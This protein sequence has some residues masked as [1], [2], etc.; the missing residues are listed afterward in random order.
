MPDV[1]NSNQIVNRGVTF[2]SKKERYCLSPAISCNLQHHT[3]V[4]VG[5]RIKRKETTIKLQETQSGW[6]VL[7]S[8]GSVVVNIGKVL[9]ALEKGDADSA[10]V[11]EGT[12]LSGAALTFVI[13]KDYTY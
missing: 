10:K 7:Y 9:V 2:F 6:S 5:N 13:I 3:Q 11:F 1:S 12:D 4:T 8:E